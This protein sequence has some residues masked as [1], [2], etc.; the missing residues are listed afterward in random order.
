[1][2]IMLLMKIIS[3][4]VKMIGTSQITNKEFEQIRRRLKMS[5]KRPSFVGLKVNKNQCSPDDLEEK[6]QA[7]LFKYEVNNDGN[8]AA[9]ELLQVVEDNPVI[10]NIVNEEFDKLAAEREDFDKLK[11]R[12]PNVS[13]ISWMTPKTVDG[14]ILQFAKQ[15]QF[16]ALL[17]PIEEQQQHAM[18]FHHFNI[19]HH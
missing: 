3:N 12:G 11:K 15:D 17:A 14:P 18:L 8:G 7:I 4:I 10:S 5:R 19:K 1:M 16:G 9:N 13:Q 2:L 6:L